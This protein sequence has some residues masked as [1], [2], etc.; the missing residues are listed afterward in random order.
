[1]QQAQHHGTG[2]RRPVT[3]VW[4]RRPPGDSQEQTPHAALPPARSPHAAL[5][6]AHVS[7]P[8]THLLVGRVLGTS[9]A[10][11]HRRLH[12]ARHPLVCQLDAPAHDKG[13]EWRRQQLSRCLFSRQGESTALQPGKAVA[14][15]AGALL[16]ARPLGALSLSL[17]LPEAAGAEHG[18]LQ[19]SCG[20]APGQLQGRDA[21][22]EQGGG[23]LVAGRPLPP[24][25]PLRPAS[26]PSNP[27]LW[28]NATQ[29]ERGGSHLHI[30]GQVLAS[31]RVV[32]INCTEE[33]EG[34]EEG[35]GGRGGG[36]LTAAARRRAARAAMASRWCEPSS[37]LLLHP[38]TSPAHTHWSP[39]P[40]Q[41]PPPPPA[42]TAES[43]EHHWQARLTDGASWGSGGTARSR[44]PVLHQLMRSGGPDCRD[45]SAK[46]VLRAAARNSPACRCSAAPPPAPPLQASTSCRSKASHHIV[47]TLL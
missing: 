31:Q 20:N 4:G 13:A 9:L 32:G 43:G 12:H 1:M 41:H 11:P 42:Q 46:A 35:E 18:S 15:Q 24:A 29:L 2:Q 40:H 22:K 33:K 25:A 44:L 39:P 7:P 34:E 5:P 21:G 14:L 19:L 6:L 28:R 23:G 47:A 37:I 45:S 16:P 8:C 17:C 3:A 38:P 26:S 27:L 10:V 30:E 36:E